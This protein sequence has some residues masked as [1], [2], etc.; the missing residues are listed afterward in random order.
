MNAK[1]DRETIVTLEKTPN[2]YLVRKGSSHLRTVPNAKYNFVTNTDGSVVMHPRYRHPPLADGKAV[3]YAGEAYFTNGKLNW[4]SNASG[5][6][7]PDDS[8]AVQAGLPMDQ[9]FTYEDILRGRQYK[10]EARASGSNSN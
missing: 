1:V 5:N 2:D 4:W 9:F 10:K 3:L 8:D 7:R 6:Y